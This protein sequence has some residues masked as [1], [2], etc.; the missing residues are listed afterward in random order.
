MTALGMAGD[1][2]QWEGQKVRKHTLCKQSTA[3]YSITLA[4]NVPF[5]FSGGCVYLLRTARNWFPS[6]CPD[7]S[8]VREVSLFVPA[9]TLLFLYVSQN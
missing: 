8:A 2:G 4:L 9:T 7:G 1:S 5:P 3:F 6:V